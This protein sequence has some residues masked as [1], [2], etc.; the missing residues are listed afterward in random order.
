MNMDLYFDKIEERLDKMSDEEFFS[1]LDESGIEKCLS[2]DK[3]YSFYIKF[4]NNKTINNRI[5][6]TY[7]SLNGYTN[8]YNVQDFDLDISKNEKVA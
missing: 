7:S 5:K 4:D 8:C 1:L 2:E 6:Y 3:E